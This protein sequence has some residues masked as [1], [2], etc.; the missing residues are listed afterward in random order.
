M[1]LEAEVEVVRQLRER[2]QARRAEELEVDA[3]E[4][5][6]LASGATKAEQEEDLRGM[7]VRGKG[8]RAWGNGAGEGGGRG[9][10]GL[11]EGDEK[12]EGWRGN[13]WSR[14]PKGGARTT[15]GNPGGLPEG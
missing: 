3:G 9:Q 15:R 10:E 7:G 2:H 4:Q 13:G 1:A 6:L 12:Y 14:V 11:F 8:R 5:C